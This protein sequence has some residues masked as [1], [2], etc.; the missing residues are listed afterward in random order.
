M[1]FWQNLAPKFLLK[2][3]IDDGLTILGELNLAFPQI[4][5]LLDPSF[6]KILREC[7]IF[8]DLGKAHI[9][10]Q[11]LLKGEAN[12][13]DGQRHELFSIPF[14]E[15]LAKNEKSSLIRPGCSRPS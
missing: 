7:V 11:K 5:S 13:W 15:S 12:K 10:F 6:W 9:E 3:H 2:Q 1:K 14:V 8:H 4:D